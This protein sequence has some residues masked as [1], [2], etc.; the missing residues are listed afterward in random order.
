MRIETPEITGQ[1]H[2]HNFSYTPRTAWKFHSENIM[3]DNKTDTVRIIH[4][5]HKL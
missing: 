5:H 3:Q 4:I 1:S 2:S